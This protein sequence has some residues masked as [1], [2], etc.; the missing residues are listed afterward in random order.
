VRFLVIPA[1]RTEL[2]RLKLARSPVLRERLDQDNWHILKAEHLRALMASEAPTLD[3]LAPLL[4]LDPP[5]ESLG[6][7]LPLFGASSEAP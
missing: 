4:G 2:V 5:V 3:A 7:Q 1:A 6:E